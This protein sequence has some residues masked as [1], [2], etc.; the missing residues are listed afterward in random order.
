MN[1]R[2]VVTGVCGGIGRAIAG[3]LRQDGWFVAGLDHPSARDTPPID[4]YKEC[5][6]SD[7]EEVRATIT[8]MTSE[9]LDLLVASAAVQPSGGLLTTTVDEWDHTFDVNVRSV[10]LAIRAAHPALRASRGSVVTIGSVHSVATSGSR[11]AY[12]SSKGALAA[13]TRAAA[14]EL[15]HDGIR[16]N[17]V[18]PG[19]IDTPMLR[20]GVT[21]HGGSLST[22]SQRTP[23]GRIGAPED[24]A[25]AVR[26]LAGTEAGFITGQSLVVDGGALARLSTE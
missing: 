19:A 21:P 15:A 3:V 2:A 20:D 12:V 5:D 6:L 1:R 25:Y 22:L 13:L 16:V 10:M 14:L 26:F 18:V 17:A 24:V 7:P 23:L 8:S 9:S 4:A 11:V